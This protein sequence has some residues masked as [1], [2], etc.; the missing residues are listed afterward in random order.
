MDVFCTNSINAQIIPIECRRLRFRCPSLE[1]DE[2]SEILSGKN[3][4]SFFAA[5]T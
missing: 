2:N 3:V 4:L 5:L 1:V